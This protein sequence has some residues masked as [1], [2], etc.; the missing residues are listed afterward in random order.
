MLPVLILVEIRCP[1]TYRIGKASVSLLAF[2]ER[3]Q[4]CNLAWVIPL[5]KQWDTRFQKKFWENL[6]GD[7]VVLNGVT[8]C[9]LPG[10]AK[11]P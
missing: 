3:P 2:L 10:K 8:F 7:R 11:T 9:N 1:Q 5:T 6:M 4:M